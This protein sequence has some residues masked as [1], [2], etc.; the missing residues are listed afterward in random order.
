MILANLRVTVTSVTDDTVELK[1]EQGQIITV[2]RQL[3]PDVTE[4]AE[5]YLAADAKPMKG[6]DEH[7]KEI[8]NEILKDE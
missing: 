4:G 2:P 5:L 7:A 1:T 8:L 6:S 3:L